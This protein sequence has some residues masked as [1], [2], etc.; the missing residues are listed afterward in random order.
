MRLDRASFVESERQPD[1]AS[2]QV[3]LQ[4]GHSKGRNMLNNPELIMLS[5]GDGICGI[6]EPKRRY[7]IPWTNDGGSYC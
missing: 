3:M 4:H 5:A 2:N 1:P 6:V 7:K